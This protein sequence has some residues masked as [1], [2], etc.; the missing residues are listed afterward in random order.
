MSDKVTEQQLASMTPEEREGYD[1]LLEEDFG[2]DE[3]G[4]QDFNNDLETGDEG[5][6]GGDNENGD[7]T[8][9][10]GNRQANDEDRSGTDKPNN[11]A[12]EVTTGADGGD[13]NNDVQ[14]DPVMP[15]LDEVTGKLKS[16]S[17]QK[18][19]LADQFDDGDLTA[20][21]Y[22]QKLK[23]LDDQEWDLRKQELNIESQRN[24][25]ESDKERLT[26]VWFETTVPNFLKEHTMYANGGTAAATLDAEVKRLQANAPSFASSLQTD[27]LLQA[28]QNIMKEFGI[29][30]TKKPN[31]DK[32]Q[33]KP[34]RELPPSLASMPAADVPDTDNDDGGAGSAL[35]HLMDTDPLKWEKALAKMPEAERERYLQ[36]RG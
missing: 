16:V 24:S 33:E 34:K 19:A 31:P 8:D 5:D 17:E 18:D 27:I 23:A 32:K 15:S 29:Q 36:R 22:R 10:T 2:E 35:D 12:E 1:L 28:H 30:D 4:D 7:D 14:P 9:E 6:E 21:E 20:K 11:S 13:V 3:N 26:S 25:I